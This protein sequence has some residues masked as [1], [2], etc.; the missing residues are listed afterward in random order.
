MTPCVSIALHGDQAVVVDAAESSLHQCHQDSR[1]RVGS[2]A[3]TLLLRRRR[4]APGS[5]RLQAAGLPTT[6]RL[7]QTCHERL[8]SEIGPRPAARRL[9]S[10]RLDTPTSPPENRRV[11]RFFNDDRTLAVITPERGALGAIDFARTRGEKPHHGSHA[12][13]KLRGV[14]TQS[15]TT[16]PYD[17]NEVA[18]KLAPW[19]AWWRFR[20]KCLRAVAG[21][22]RAKR[23]IGHRGDVRCRIRVNTETAA[24]HARVSAQVIWPLTFRVADG[25]KPPLTTSRA[26]PDAPDDESPSHPGETITGRTRP[27]NAPT[28]VRITS[29]SE[30]PPPMC[31]LTR[32]PT[33]SATPRSSLPAVM[34]R[35]SAAPK[36]VEDLRPRRVH[37][38]G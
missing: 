19:V 30:S 3:E 17:L 27:V 38:H 1:C 28:G 20:Q 23:A 14:R 2:R 34:K 32:N 29:G 35:P 26:R 31:C 36:G 37:R 4:D 15:R 21:R 13:R 18:S 16:N 11:H 25:P 8:T 10:Y 12:T 6:R 7:Q 24:P 5:F 33:A 22:C 9:V